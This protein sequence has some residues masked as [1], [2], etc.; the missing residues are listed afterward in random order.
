M[1]SDVYTIDNK[2][3]PRSITRLKIQH[4]RTMDHDH[5]IVQIILHYSCTETSNHLSCFM[6]ERKKITGLKT[7]GV[8]YVFSIVKIP[9]HVTIE[10]YHDIISSLKPWTEWQAK[11]LLI[12][13]RFISSYPSESRSGMDLIS[14]LLKSRDG[15]KSLDRKARSHVRRLLPKDHQDPQLWRNPRR[16]WFSPVF[17]LLEVTEMARLMWCT[18]FTMY[19]IENECLCIRWRWGRCLEDHAF[20]NWRVKNH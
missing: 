1:D 19:K 7:T 14:S 11:T 3:W 18:R 15:I 16:I 5:F 10:R 8:F 2:Q 17:V 13:S 20:Q 9:S 12:C 6:E 4:V